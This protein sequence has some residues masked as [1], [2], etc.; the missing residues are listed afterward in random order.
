MIYLLVIVSLLRH[1][2]I[3]AVLD[4]FFIVFRFLHLA[5]F[6]LFPLLPFSLSPPSP[7]SSLFPLP[8]TE[9]LALLFPELGYGRPA[10]RQTLQWGAT[11]RV[12][13]HANYCILVH[14]HPQC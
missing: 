7:C 10:D 1:F 8:F 11:V 14:D 12:Y 13:F 9:L 5:C 2:S 4:S 3:C 6:P